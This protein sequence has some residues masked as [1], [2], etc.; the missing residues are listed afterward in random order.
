VR[1]APTAE[2]RGQRSQF[3]EAFGPDDRAIPVERL[4]RDLYAM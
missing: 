3:R 4:R 1:D 2:G